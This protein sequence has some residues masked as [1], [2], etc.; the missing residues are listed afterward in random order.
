M[1][2]KATKGWW[3]VTLLF[4][5]TGFAIIIYLNQKPFEPR[6]RDYAYAAS[7]YAFS[8]WIGMSVLALYD[9][10]KS[11]E[12]KELATIVGALAGLGLI[13]SI[14]DL[15]AGISMFYIAG[16]IAGAYALMIILRSS[17]KDEKQGAVISFLI[18]IPVPLLMGMQAW[19]DH[20]RSNRYTAQALAE[21]YLNSCGEN[22]IIFTNG[23]NDTFPLWYLQEVE[24]KKTDV[25]VCNLSL[26]NT[27]WY[28][29]QMTRK[30]YESE[31]LPISFTEEQYR[32]NGYRDYMYVLGTNQL[33]MG[34]P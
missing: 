20:D 9:A 13:L 10:F 4:M 27:D 3:L 6:E 30:A 22:G 25:R 19:D 16:V 21:N 34:S 31:P 11:M 8:I 18:A 15:T 33:T 5:L 24:G 1:M 26:L 14:G 28:T 32:Q 2:T 12:W 17:L 23:D 29:E 7:F